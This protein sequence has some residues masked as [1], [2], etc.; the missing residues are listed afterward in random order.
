[1]VGFRD[2][3]LISLLI[4]IAL[5]CRAQQPTYETRIEEA[6]G[7]ALCSCIAYMNRSVDSLSAINKD[8]SGSYFVQLSHLTLDEMVKMTGSC[9]MAT[10]ASE[11]AMQYSQWK[12]IGDMWQELAGTALTQQ[13]IENWRQSV[14]PS[15]HIL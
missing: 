6:K 11:L 4:G 8:Y 13:A 7:Y 3:L 15:A 10:H 9:S 12:A 2:I 5:N 1:M 14:S